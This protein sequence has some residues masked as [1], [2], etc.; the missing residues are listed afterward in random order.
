MKRP[1]ASLVAVVPLTVSLAGAGGD[2]V[3]A[4]YT[5][6]VGTVFVDS[7]GVGGFEVVRKRRHHH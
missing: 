2:A 6:R 4:S 7:V 3:T 1:V 5:A